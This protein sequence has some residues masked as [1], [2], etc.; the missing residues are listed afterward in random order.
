MDFWV[1]IER[2]NHIISMEGEE[3]VAELA[4]SFPD[5]IYFQAE[6]VA[7]SSRYARIRELESRGILG[8]ELCPDP[9]FWH[10]PVIREDLLPVE[11]L[12]DYEMFGE[13]RYY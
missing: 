6:L 13:I 5:T 9:Y 8:P 12:V 7:P 10:W 11:F 4:S 3:F 1:Y 2:N